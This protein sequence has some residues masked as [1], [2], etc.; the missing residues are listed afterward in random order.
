MMRALEVIKATGQSIFHFQRGEK[1]KRDFAVVKIGLELPK[2]ELHRNIN[3]RVDKMV[4]QG[5][6]EEVKALLPHQHLNALQT[7]G[8]KEIFQYLNGDVSLQNAM[9]AI[10]QNTRQYAKRQ[11][12]WFRKDKEYH[13][14]SPDANTIIDFLKAKQ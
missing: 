12:T 3:H 5:L 7:V 13:W 9:E 11:L 14:A 6:L 2:D 8:Y 4:E 10:K 1:R